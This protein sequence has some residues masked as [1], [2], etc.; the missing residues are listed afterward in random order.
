MSTRIWLKSLLHGSYLVD[1]DSPPRPTR[2]TP[3]FSVLLVPAVALGGLEAGV[4]VV[5]VSVLVLGCLAA[6]LAWRIGGGLAAT[7]A[8]LLALFNIGVYVMAH[9]I[10]SDLPSVT[11]AVAELTLIALTVGSRSAV[12][13]GFLAGCLVWIRPGSLVLVLAGLAAFSAN[14]RPEAPS[15]RLRGQPCAAASGIGSMAVVGLRF[16]AHHQLSGNRCEWR[17]LV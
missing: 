7:L 6:L 1:Y 11:I 16:A 5:Y 3:G 4:W 8:G 15:G 2:Y 17:W 14:S 10:M 13:A 9:S 12:A